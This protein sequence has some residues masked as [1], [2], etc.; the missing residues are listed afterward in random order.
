MPFV[1][2]P[3]VMQVEFRYL[4]EGQRCENRIMVDALGTVTDALLEST[5]ILAWNWWEATYSP[6][7][8]TNTFL[9]EVLVTDMSAAD[10]GQFT[11]APDSA[12]HGAMG[13]PLP[14]EAAFCISLR[15]SGRGRSARGRWFACSLSGADRSDPNTLTVGYVSDLVSALNVLRAALETAGTPWVIVSYRNG[16]IPR[17]GGPVKYLVQNCIATDNLIDSQRRRKPGVGS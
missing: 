6:S 10:G 4:L 3:D 9:S 15:T 7:V 11:Y 2:S 14:N 12:T 1:P 13:S 16:G 5:A 8:G 17:P